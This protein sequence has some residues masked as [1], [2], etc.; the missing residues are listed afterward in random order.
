M[1]DYRRI[2]AGACTWCGHKPHASA[3]SRSIR[4]RDPMPHGDDVDKPCPCPRRNP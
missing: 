2:E 4:T 3:C 1:T